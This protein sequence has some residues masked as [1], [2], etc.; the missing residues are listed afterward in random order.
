[1]HKSI[2]NYWLVYCIGRCVV[3][4]RTHTHQSTDPNPIEHQ[5]RLAYIH[6]NAEHQVCNDTNLELGPP[7]YIYAG[8]AHLNTNAYLWW[9]VDSSAEMMPLPRKERRPVS[10]VLSLTLILH[11]RYECSERWCLRLDI[12]NAAS[13]AS[14]VSCSD[15][16]ISCS[17]C[18][19]SG[20]PFSWRVVKGMAVV[21]GNTA[22]NICWCRGRSQ[23]SISDDAGRRRNR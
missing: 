21:E 8:H 4:P 14:S 3:Q 2:G 22:V 13:Q 16:A 10:A 15:S 6:N 17:F 5:H 23:Y 12:T 9:R 1:M 7:K 19:R 18:Q 20:E 11:E